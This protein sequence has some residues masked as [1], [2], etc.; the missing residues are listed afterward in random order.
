MRVRVTFLYLCTSQLD[1]VL[2]FLKTVKSYRFAEY[3]EVVYLYTKPV[4]FQSGVPKPTK[5]ASTGNVLEM[6][7]PD[8]GWGPAIEFDKPPR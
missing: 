4:I 7:I 8:W 3:F 1:I 5:S 6:Q 2:T